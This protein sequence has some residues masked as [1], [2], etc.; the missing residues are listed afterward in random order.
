[1]S[2]SAPD[3]PISGSLSET[4][5]YVVL[6]QIQRERRSGTLSVFR[7]DQVRQ[8]VFDDGELRQ[9][10]SSREDHRIGATLVRWGY[11]SQKDLEAALAAQK[12]TR[13]RI[14]RILVERGLVT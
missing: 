14:D 4:P 8:L 12:Q 1:M 13:E 11:I 3:T 9:A 5:L 7:E 10:R 6:R 2:P